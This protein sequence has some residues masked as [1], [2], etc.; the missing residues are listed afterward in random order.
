MPDYRIAHIRERNVDLIIVPLDARF[1]TLPDDQQEKQI[2]AIQAQAARI[3]LAGTVIPV[4]DL[5]RGR[6]GFRAPRNF[7]QFFET[8]SLK[9]VSQNINRKLSW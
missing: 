6:M 9:F 8:I 7:H 4:W 2:V 1:G 3:G 5:G